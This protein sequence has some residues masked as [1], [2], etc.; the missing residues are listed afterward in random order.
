[1]KKSEIRSTKF[2]TNSNAQSTKFKTVL[3]FGFGILILFSISIFGFRIS[4]AKAGVETYFFDYRA[5]SVSDGI[6]QLNLVVFF[7][8]KVSAFPEPKLGIGAKLII[9]R[10]P[11]ITVLDGSQETIYHSW[12]ENLADFLGEK[13]IELGE[14]DKIVPP[15][16]TT[17]KDGDKIKITRVAITEI[18]EKEIVAFKII[19]QND[20]NLDKGKTVV[21]QAGI[22]GTREKTYRVTR[23]NGKEVKRELISN[24]ITKD[25]QDKIIIHGT[26][27]VV[28]G[29]GRA[30]WY[31][32][33]RGNTAAH[34]S[35][36]KG[37]IVRVTNLKNG[38]SVVVKIIDRGIMGGAII[39]L[40]KDAFVQI[41]SLSEGV[42]DVKITQE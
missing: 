10:A 9:A 28:L 6:K 30:T 35:L 42:I 11:T 12:Q 29:A 20:D 5:E 15:V 22:N 2:E 16:N 34:N 37:T 19:E 31:D 33:V 8:D 14:N 18:K 23:E 27:V 36:P 40:A 3:N 24:K 7:E 13:N 1:M 38:K 39:D 4:P 41:G 17:I 32:L 25:P 26:K 21:K